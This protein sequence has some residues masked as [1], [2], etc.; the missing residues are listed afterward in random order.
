MEL[1]ESP[2]LRVIPAPAQAVSELMDLLK[3][4]P[5]VGGDIFDLQIVATMSA[6]GIHRIYTFNVKDFLRLPELE[7][8]EP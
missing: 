5:A 4:H 6:N 2:G 1:L 3:R 8:V 7:V